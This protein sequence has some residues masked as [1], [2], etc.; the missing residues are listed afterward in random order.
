MLLR[1]YLTSKCQGQEGG[2]TVLSP[3]CC[4]GAEGSPNAKTTLL[5][6]G[7]LHSIVWTLLSLLQQMVSENRVLVTGRRNQG[8]PLAALWSEILGG[9]GIPITSNVVC[10]MGEEV[11]RSLCCCSCLP[12]IL[13][14]LFLREITDHH[15][16]EE[17]K[18][19]ISAD[20]TEAQLFNSTDRARSYQGLPYPC[21][22]NW[23]LKLPWCYQGEGAVES[24]SSFLLIPLSPQPFQTGHWSSRLNAHWLHRQTINLFHI[25]YHH[26]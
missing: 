16:P 2:D 19:S 11:R 26:S 12:M 8:P 20:R 4:T 9:A 6:Q 23:N 7:T 24:P 25:T 18:G 22:N 21:G 5:C 3:L 10:V 1:R 15:L 13:R 14:C 17:K